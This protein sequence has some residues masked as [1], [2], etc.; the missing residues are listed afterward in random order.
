MRYLGID[1]GIKRVGIALSDRSGILA[2]PHAILD[3]KN[4]LVDAIVKLCQEEHVDA[5][6]IGESLDQ[7]GQPNA[8]MEEVRSLEKQLQESLKL[9][10]YFEKEWYSS[11]AAQGHLYGKGN[12][13]KERWTGVMNEKRREHVDDKAAA[14]I[15]QRFL[16]RKKP[17]LK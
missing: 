13:A 4:N 3:S 10:I 6:V 16:D 8:I 15:L 1:Y 17:S 2:Q 5:L 7:E 12:I 14:V 11:V 9:P